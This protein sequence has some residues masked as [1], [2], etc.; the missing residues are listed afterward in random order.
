M[1][2]PPPPAPPKVEVTQASLQASTRTASIYQRIF[3]AAPRRIPEAQPAAEP[4]ALEAPA[5]VVAGTGDNRSS[6]P[7]ALGL[8]IEKPSA[9][10][11]VSAV[12]KQNN[13]PAAPI[14]VSIGVQMAKLIKQVIPVY[15]PM[16]KMMR[17]S[18]VVHLVG[19][20]G[21]DGRVQ[22]LQLISG[23]PIL[24]HAAME[25]VQQWIYRPTLLSGE[26][27]EVTAPIDVNFTLT[28]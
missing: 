4:L 11:P 2:G 24:A 18:G 8:I 16:A 6:I 20:I 27:V 3:V 9:P 23:H 28:Q 7:S 22:R 19:V 17:I 21:K 25:A 5:A 1:L 26:P 10:Q 14:R 15:P 12:P 13:A